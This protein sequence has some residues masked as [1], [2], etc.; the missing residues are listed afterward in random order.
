[1]AEQK[2][3]QPSKPQAG[4]PSAASPQKKPGISKEQDRSRK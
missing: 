3:N 1:M 4:K 2:K